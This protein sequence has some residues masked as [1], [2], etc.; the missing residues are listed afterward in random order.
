MIITEGA[1]ISFIF[2]S[3]IG[4]ISSF[5]IFILLIS[6]ENKIRIIEIERDN[7]TLKASLEE[8]KFLHLASQIKPHF[9]FNVLNTIIS[10]L[11]F[12]QLEKAKKAMYSLSRL[13]RFS[14]EAKQTCKLREESNYVRDYL[15]IEKIRFEKRLD[16]DI[17]I[18]PVLLEREV[19]SFCLL[20]LVENIFKHSIEIT[21]KPILI[22]VGGT[23]ENNLVK[24]SVSD[25]GIGMSND[26]ISAFNNWKLSYENESGKGSLPTEHIGLQNVYSRMKYL[27]GKEF[28]MTIENSGGTKVT[29]I[30]PN[31]RI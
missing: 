7:V 29:L 14:I 22:S 9:L 20:T 6:F 25:N 16:F 1:F 2:I 31:E 27:I 10:L 15:N 8:T 12:K 13:L 21:E 23:V 11:H 4:S 3:I 17:D 18:D 24:L 30:F 5:I 19:P 26:K 28:S